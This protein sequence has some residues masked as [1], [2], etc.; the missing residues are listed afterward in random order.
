MTRVSFVKRRVARFDSMSETARRMRFVPVFSKK[1]LRLVDAGEAYPC[2]EKQVVLQELVFFWVSV[3][4]GALSS[5][6]WGFSVLWLRRCAG[7]SS[8]DDETAK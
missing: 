2:E 7:E 4:W 8:S 6:V 1:M 5:S 3:G